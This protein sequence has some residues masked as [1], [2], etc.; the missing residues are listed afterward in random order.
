LLLAGKA[1]T[2][3]AGSAGR[4]EHTVGIIALRQGHGAA[5]IGQLAHGTERV[6][7]EILR[8]R[9]ADLRNA[10]CPVQ[11]GMRAVPLW[12]TFVQH[13][14]Q[15]GSQVHGEGGG[16]VVDRLLESMTNQPPHF[17]TS[18]GRSASPASPKSTTSRMVDNKTSHCEFG[19]RAS[20]VLGE[21]AH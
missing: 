21:G 17:N 15:A 20:H 9:G 2:A 11:V 3:G 19:G 4:I 13:L 12:G 8:I 5:G 7:Q 16:D 10:A 14:G 18:S 6:A 1:V